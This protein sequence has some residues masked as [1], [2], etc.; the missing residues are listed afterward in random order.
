MSPNLLLIFFCLFFGVLLKRL[1]AFP[2]SAPKAFNAFVIWVSFPAVIFLQV[3]ALLDSAGLTWELFIPAS[4]PWIAFILAFGVFYGLGRQFKW[5]RSETGALILTA[6][7]GNTS[8]VGFPLLEAILGPESIRIAVVVDEIGSFF[9]ASTLALVVASAMSPQMNRGARVG[10]I[11]KKILSFPPFIAML[12]ACG[13][14]ASGGHRLELPAAVLHKLAAP[15]IPLALISVGLQLRFSPAVFRR[16]WKPLSLGLAFKLIL[17][18][19]FFVGLYVFVLGSHSFATHVTL[20]E[21]A[22][23]PMITSAIIAEDF[24]LNPEIA[25]LMV[26]VGIPLSIATVYLWNYVLTPFF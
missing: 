3:P 4:M 19:A 15:L 21:S 10:P 14:W 24:D 2:A 26:G 16:Q 11:V 18:P 8:F 25:N 9:V 5:S 22:M 12:L 13:W 7:L 17:A 23:A 20:L 1:G 6:G